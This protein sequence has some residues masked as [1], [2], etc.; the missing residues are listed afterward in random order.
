MSTKMKDGDLLRL[1]EEHQF[2]NAID[3]RN[4]NY[5]KYLGSAWD[6]NNTDYDALY[7]NWV[8]NP[9]FKKPKPI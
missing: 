6:W 7:F 3:P 9:E 8:D 1:M 2:D 4:G 5:Y